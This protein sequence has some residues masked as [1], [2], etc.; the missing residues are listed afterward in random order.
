MVG[1]GVFLKIPR[2]QN[3]YALQST[4]ITGAAITVTLTVSAPPADTSTEPPLSAPSAD[5][6]ID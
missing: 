4:E 3:T 6:G 2:P 1:D 5:D